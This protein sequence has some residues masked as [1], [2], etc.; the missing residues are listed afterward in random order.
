MNFLPES[1]IKLVEELRNL[2]GIGPKSAQRLAF[3]LLKTPDGRVERL[4][5]TIRD[6]KKGVLTC[7]TCFTLCTKDPCAICQDGTRDTEI[8]CVVE[9]SLDMVAIEKTGEYKGLYHVLQ[10][11]LSPLDGIGPEHIRFEELFSRLA[12]PSSEIKEVIFALNPDLEGDT[13]ALF[14]HQK[15]SS[16]S[17]L[18]VSRIARGIPSGGNLE[19]AD[20]TTL[21][22]AME[23]RQ[24][25]I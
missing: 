9:Q 10:G 11:R 19:Y 25:M 18:T 4:S 17:S 23:G 2:P 21:I 22:R 12:H 1:I 5:D 24:K 14:L 3:H 8:L 15:L 16:L 6:V 20:E 7:S 13:T